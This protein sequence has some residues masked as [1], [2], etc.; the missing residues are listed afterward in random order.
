[1]NLKATNDLYGH[2]A[3]DEYLK[4]FAEL[5]CET[6]RGCPVYRIGGDEF[7]VVFRDV[8][9]ETVRSDWDALR[10]RIE[11]I[12]SEQGHS[13]SAAF[14]YAFWDASGL[15]TIEKVFKEA[16]DRMYLHKK[17]IRGEAK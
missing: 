3:G 14:G 2:Q 13:I 12:K 5:L 6:F 15:D 10:R 8:P 9:E 7:A 4:I 16:D 17:Q 11:V 1:N